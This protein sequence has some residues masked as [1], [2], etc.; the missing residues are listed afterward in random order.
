MTNMI[1]SCPTC[2]YNR[3][4]HL[5]MMLFDGAGQNEIYNKHAPDIYDPELKEHQNINWD[6]WPFCG[7]PPPNT[8]ACPKC[9]HHEPVAGDVL[10]Q[11]EDRPRLFE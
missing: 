10:A 11:L 5:P 7:P 9:G 4:D 1:K 8:W 3:G 2:R 6:Q